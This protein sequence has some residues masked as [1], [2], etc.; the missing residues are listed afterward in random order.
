MNAYKFNSTLELT[1][2][3]P[4][5]PFSF[6]EGA[7][8]ALTPPLWYFVMNPYVDEALDRAKEVSKTH[9]KMVFYIKEGISLAIFV[10]PLGSLRSLHSPVDFLRM[11]YP[12]QY[13][14][15][16]R[17]KSSQ[18]YDIKASRR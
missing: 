16:C 14:S 18:I 6:N 4:R 7:Y 3:M 15:S 13:I 2:K 8:I 1:A 5:F 9:Q 12:P 11:I 10:W 17:F